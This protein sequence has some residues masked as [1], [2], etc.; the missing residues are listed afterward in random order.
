MS[1]IL[2]SIR[3]IP[4][5]NNN[6][7][8]LSLPEY[9]KIAKKCISY[10]ANKDSEKEMLC[11]EDAISYIVEN[12][13]IGDMRWDK[14]GGM[15]AYN[16]RNNCARWAILTWISSRKKLSKNKYKNP[17][18]MTNWYYT[19]TL[20]EDKKTKTPLQKAIENETIENLDTT[21]KKANLTDRQIVCLKCRFLDQMKYREIAKI[22]G[23]SSNNIPRLEVKKAINKIKKYVKFS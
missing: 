4:K 9:I 2:K 3:K 19:Q 18:K 11:N 14:N 12:M 15:S 5:Q 13:I 23:V 16:Y 1:I 10:F 20:M 22:I 6:N 21:L 17:Q 7:E 8:L